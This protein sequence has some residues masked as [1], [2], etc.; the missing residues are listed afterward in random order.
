MR[1]GVLAG[2]IFGLALFINNCIFAA[3]LWFEGEA[4]YFL[5]HFDTPAIARQKAQKL[6]LHAALQ[7]AISQGKIRVEICSKTVVFNGRLALDLIRSLSAAKVKTV[8]IIS[9]QQGVKNKQ[10]FWKVKVRALLEEKIELA[11]FGLGLKLL[12]Y[13]F[14]S[15][16]PVKGLFLSAKRPCYPYLY[17]V[18][19]KGTVYRLLPNQYQKAFLLKGTIAFPTK[20][21]HEAGVELRAYA[22]KK[23]PTL[24]TEELLLIC[25]AE[26]DEFLEQVF[27][28]ALAEE[29]NKVEQILSPKF[30]IK[31]EEIVKHLYELPPGTWSMTEAIY[32]VEQ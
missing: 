16:E 11:D 3:G 7:K 25:T 24:Q 31:L 14:K 18:T 29:E 13:R 1:R 19:T 30:K 2:L 8:Q 23:G 17:S 22:F 26:K 4:C 6:A 5:S 12:K 32:K 28:D 21:M 10:Y 27:P 15:G 9:E 20:A